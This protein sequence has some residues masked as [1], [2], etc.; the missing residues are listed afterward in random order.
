MGVGRLSASRTDS[1]TTP[2]FLRKFP[3][4]D[5]LTPFWWPDL[6]SCLSDPT[7]YWTC[8]SPAPCLSFRRKERFNHSDTSRYRPFPFTSPVEWKGSRDW[9]VLLTRCLHSCPWD[10]WPYLVFR[11]SLS[12]F[13]GIPFLPVPQTGPRVVTIPSRRCRIVSEL[14]PRTDVDVPLKSQVSSFELFDRPVFNKIPSFF[15]TDV[16]LG[17][18][19]I[20]N[21]VLWNLSLLHWLIR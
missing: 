20:E 21:D 8:I 12:T 18:S 13:H 16:G 11:A 19:D 3:T 15:F 17:V 6:L 5:S 9:W 10:G 4:S 2:R 14:P 1:T 7:R